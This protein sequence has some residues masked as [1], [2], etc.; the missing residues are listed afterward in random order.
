LPLH[1]H[2]VVGN[3]ARDIASR[4]SLLTAIWKISSD[5]KSVICFGAVPS[6]GTFHRFPMRFYAPA[7]SHVFGAVYDTHATGAQFL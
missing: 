5:L 3:I 2:Y 1:Q 7:Q 4:A 6:I